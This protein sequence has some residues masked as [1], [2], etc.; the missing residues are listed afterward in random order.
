[1]KQNQLIEISRELKLALVSSVIIFVV[2]VFGAW[3]DLNHTDTVLDK[4]MEI[5]IQ[6]VDN[7]TKA[8]DKIVEGMEKNSS[9]MEALKES[10]IK[11]ESKIDQK[12]DK[13]RRE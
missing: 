2:G 4:R 5:I 7:N 10:I 9:N 8:F 13:Y 11:L 12:A 1:M 3:Q 6:Q